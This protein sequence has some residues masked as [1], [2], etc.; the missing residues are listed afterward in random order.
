MNVEPESIKIS[1]LTGDAK[2]ALGEAPSA[3]KLTLGELNVSLGD[4]ETLLK[5]M[6]T[7][8][9]ILENFAAIPVLYLMQQVKYRH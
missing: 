8:A 4:I 7:Q 3:D 5:D 2:N 6:K 1:G 9:A